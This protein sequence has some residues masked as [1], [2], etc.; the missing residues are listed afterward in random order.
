MSD[1]DQVYEAV[2]K[3]IG[4]SR[5]YPFL[6]V[7]SGMSRRY[8]GSPDWAGLLNSIC[9]EAL[10]DEFAYPRFVTEARSQLG[11]STL[12]DSQVDLLPKVASL[13]EVEIGREVLESERMGSFREAHRDEIM[14]SIPPIKLLVSAMLDQL[15]VNRRFSGTPAFGR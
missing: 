9:S 8:L 11:M 12:D 2:A 3:V 14:R 6:F 4:G 5:R 1:A 10:G 15:S 7:G 13:M